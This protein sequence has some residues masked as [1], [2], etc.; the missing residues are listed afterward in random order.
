[1]VEGKLTFLRGAGNVTTV[2]PAGR[3]YTVPTGEF[4]K[5]SNAGTTGAAF[6]VAFLLPKGGALT[7]P[8]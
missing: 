8:K 3:T 6:V 5:V 2:V 7:T 4:I 1:M